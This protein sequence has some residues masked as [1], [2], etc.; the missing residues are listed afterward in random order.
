[1]GRL[2][3]S[4]FQTKTQEDVERLVGYLS[5]LKPKERYTFKDC[6]E[7]FKTDELKIKFCQLCFE[8]GI[9]PNSAVD[10]LQ[11]LKRIELTRSTKAEIYEFTERPKG[12]DKYETERAKQKRKEIRNAIKKRQQIEKGLMLN[13]Q[14]SN[15]QNCSY[16]RNTDLPNVHVGSVFSV[17][18]RP[19]I[20]AENIL[21]INFKVSQGEIRYG[22]YVLRSVR[23]KPI[24]SKILSQ[25]VVVR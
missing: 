23:I 4:Y 17:E 20:I 1:M 5:V 24:S 6:I 13:S 14:L 22:E 11:V 10:I 18:Y 8:R 3:L 7:K 15:L 19:P 21:A 16:E 12:Y 25:I 2:P 9:Y